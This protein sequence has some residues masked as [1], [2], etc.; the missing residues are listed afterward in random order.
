MTEKQETEELPVQE[1]NQRRQNKR[2]RGKKSKKR[3][4]IQCTALL[5]VVCV[6]GGAVFGISSMMKQS[7][8]NEVQEGFVTVSY[9]L[10]ED[11]STPDMHSALENIGYMKYRLMNQLAWYS[12]MHGGVDTLLKQTVSTYKQYEDGVMIQADITRSSLVNSA[13]QFCYVGDDV[14]WREA[15]GSPSTWAQSYEELAAMDWGSGDPAGRMTVAEFT[16]TRGL[17]GTEFSVYVINEETLLSADEVVAVGDGVYSQTYYLDPALDKAPC[18]YANQMVTTG[19]LSALPEFEYITV[20]YTFDS[21]WQVLSS[22]VQE[23]YTASM[24]FTVSCE[25]QYETNYEYGTAR[26]HSDDYEN[27]YSDYT[28]WQGGEALPAEPTVVGCLSDAFGGVMAE[29]TA[30]HLALAVDGHA[31]E[32][33]I[34][35]D[36]AQMDIRARLGDLSLWYAADERIYVDYQGIRVRLAVAELAGLF[37]E[38]SLGAGSADPLAEEALAG[39]DLNALLEDLA[40]GIFRYDDTGASLETSLELF[41]LSIP[42]SFSFA[43]DEENTASLDFVAAELPLG[44][45]TLSARLTPC[46]PQ[47]RFMQIS[48]T[49]AE[50]LQSRAIFY[51]TYPPLPRRQILHL[52]I[53][54]LRRLRNLFMRT[55]P[56]ISRWTS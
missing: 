38:G 5:G 2:K 53:S 33:D 34:Y 46:S 7:E 20:T 32:G 37:S 23:A 36:I 8:P 25:A 52:S 22:T 14:F 49:A 10:P 11:G 39:L 48:R 43:L 41:G 45:V 30:F 54:P 17:P 44:E 16:Q 27:Y 4:I 6:A 1:Q 50:S 26:A 3:R 29:P 19:G 40:A 13:R 9:P 21:T 42:L 12:E 35:A 15:P 55:I 47:T 31:L 51:S 56:S 28:D 18:H 24:G